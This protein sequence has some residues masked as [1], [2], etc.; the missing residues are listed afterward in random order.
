V[1][2]WLSMDSCDFVCAFDCCKVSGFQPG[3]TS[4]L[5]CSLYLLCLE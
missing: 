2:V 4:L 3:V 1:G 5:E